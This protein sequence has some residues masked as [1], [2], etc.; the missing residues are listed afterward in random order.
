MIKSLTAKIVRKAAPTYYK[1]CEWNRRFSALQKS[2]HE[3]E[4]HIAPLLCDKDKTSIDVGAASGSYT[5]HVVAASRDCLAF[6]PRPAQA[7]ELNEMVRYLSL[8]VRVEAVALSDMPGE[9]RLRTLESD[10]GRS[11]IERDNP[12]EDPDGSER[13][14]FVVPMRRLDDYELDS[15]GFIK[16]DVEGH[17]LAVLRGGLSTLRR[18]HPIMLIEIEERHKRN[19]I[20]DVCGVLGDLGYEGYFILNRKLISMESFDLVVHQNSQNIG[21]WKDNWKRYGIYINNFIFVPLG[22][23]ARLEAAVRKVSN[24]LSGS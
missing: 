16:I 10:L 4:L 11:T 6:E 22:G 24:R 23:S 3:Q 18:C 9:A 19:S 21:G 20:A 14:E 5:V 15:V 7:S 1:R 12:L 13:S 2:Y 17:E 8:P